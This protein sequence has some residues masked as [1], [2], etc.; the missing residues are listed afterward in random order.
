M[1]Y[2]PPRAIGILI[3]ATLTLWGAAVA[4]LLINHAIAV[5]FGFS[6]VLTIAG[7]IAAATVAVLFG[8]WTYAL[9]TLSYELDRN[10]LVIYWGA[11]RQVIPLQEIERI[12]PGTSVAIA[13]VQG[14]SWLG[15]H[16]GLASIEHVG[17]VLFYSTHQNEKQVLY[18]IT[19]DRNYAISVDDPNEFAREVQ[20]RQ[21]L[22]PTA[23][24]ATHAQRI[25][26]TA[27]AF[28][29]DP[30]GRVLVGTA[31]LAN[32]LMWTFV[33]LRY[34]A[35]PAVFEMQFPAY[36]E[37]ELINPQTKDS[38]LQLPLIA[39]ILL[40][41]NLLVGFVLHTWARIT[42]YLLFIVAIIVQLLFTGAIAIAIKGV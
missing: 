5:N 30:V 31:L 21:D 28:W 37:S 32:F 24:I 8:Y 6:V 41:I 1:T 22:G 25:G 14:V 33:S 12:V 29:H 19:S 18:V 16:V 3:G 35:L 26:S 36:E 23:P 15:Y 9:G 2:Q 39:T 34:P 11:T 4:I 27:Q 20:I 40:V 13:P 17:D 10:G 38:I 42:S 7:S